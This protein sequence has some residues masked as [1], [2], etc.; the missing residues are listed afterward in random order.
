MP[1]YP[2]A[3]LL[4]PSDPPDLPDGFTTL[5]SAM[6]NGLPHPIDL[7]NGLRLTVTVPTGLLSDWIDADPTMVITTSDD[8]SAPLPPN[9]NGEIAGVARPGARLSARLSTAPL[10]TL[11]L[12]LR[13][14]R[15]LRDDGDAS[16][17]AALEVVLLDWEIHAGTL[18]GAGDF[19]SS[20]TLAWR[21]ADQ[22]VSAFGPPV[23]NPFLILRLPPIFHLRSELGLLVRRVDTKFLLQRR[24]LYERP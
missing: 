24:A 2:A 23:I 14:A 5:Q 1:S 19:G 12:S 7:P 17:G 8:E 22:G 16:A 15:V 11:P 4:V 13:A 3:R 18:R 6:V 10:G 21:R 9:P 20:I